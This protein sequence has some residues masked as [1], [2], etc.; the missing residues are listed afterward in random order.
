LWAGARVLASPQLLHAVE[1]A[2]I[3]HVGIGSDYDGIQRTPQELEDAS[4]YMNL[5]R[6]LRQR[7]FSNEELVKVLG[8]NFERVYAAVTGLGTAAE[9]AQLVALE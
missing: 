2:G 5:A 4:C 8:G 9:R 3:D 7:G 1:I 6:G